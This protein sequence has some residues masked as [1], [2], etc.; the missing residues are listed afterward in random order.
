MVFLVEL[1]RWYWLVIQIFETPETLMADR[2]QF[3]YAAWPLPCPSARHLAPTRH[4]DEVE[5]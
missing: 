1:L 5:N 2:P 3:A 4:Q